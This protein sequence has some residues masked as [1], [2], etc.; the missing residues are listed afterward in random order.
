MLNPAVDALSGEQSS[1]AGGA[2]PVAVSTSV[3]SLLAGT[4]AGGSPGAAGNRQGVFLEADPN[5]TAASVIYV[6]LGPGTVSASNYHFALLPGASVGFGV[7]G[8]SNGIWRGAVSCIGSTTG[9]KL[10]AAVC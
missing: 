6:L 4:A 5:N 7:L 8:G 10:A 3:V 1:L 9:L 2:S